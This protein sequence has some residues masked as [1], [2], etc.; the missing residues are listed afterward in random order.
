M[1]IALRLSQRV[2][3]ENGLIHLI[4]ICELEVMNK[5]IS[6]V[7]V[8]AILRLKHGKWGGLLERS[9]SRESPHIL[10]RG[11]LPKTTKSIMKRSGLPPHSRMVP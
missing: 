8:R 10:G 7:S 6:G 4:Y 5:E 2:D 1:I 9:V 11:G 3:I